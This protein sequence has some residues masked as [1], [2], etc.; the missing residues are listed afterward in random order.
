MM[1]EHLSIQPEKK[2]TSRT[3]G[4]LFRQTVV[5]RGPNQKYLDPTFRVRRSERRIT[6]L[7]L[8][9]RMLSVYSPICLALHVYWK[10]L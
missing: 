6:Y 7:L 4:R 3:S 1:L 2:R 10:G 8:R 9:R 5:G